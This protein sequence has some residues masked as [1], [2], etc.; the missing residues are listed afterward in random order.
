[1][2]YKGGV[3]GLPINYKSPTLI[4]NKDLVKTPPKTTDEMVKLAKTLT[5]RAVGPLSA[6]PTGTPTSTSTR[7]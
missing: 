5:E 4:Y 7:R 2:T 1:M 3:Y 6:W